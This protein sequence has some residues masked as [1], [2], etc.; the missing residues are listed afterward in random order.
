VTVLPET[1]RAYVVV[2]GARSH[3]ASEIATAC[4]REGPGRSSSARFHESSP[5]AFSLG[6]RVFIG[7]PLSS[8]LSPGISLFSGRGGAPGLSVRLGGDTPSGLEDS[9][10]SPARRGGGSIRRRRRSRS[11]CLP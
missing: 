4:T 8:S 6:A 2:P 1:Y 5:R 10:T 11:P 3:L 7:V 9:A